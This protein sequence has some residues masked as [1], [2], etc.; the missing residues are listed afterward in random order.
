[1]GFATQS[2][3]TRLGL[4]RNQADISLDGTGFF[5]SPS[6]HCDSCYQ[7]TSKSGQVTYHH[8]MLVEFV[9]NPSHKQVLPL[10]FEPISKEDGQVKNDCERNAAKRWLNKYRT[11]TLI[12]QARSWRRGLRPKCPSYSSA[13]GSSMPLHFGGR[14]KTTINFCTSG[15]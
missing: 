13:S 15:F 3:F 10:P 7:K 8:Q 11:S 12:C 5:S 6:I 14:R 9:V 1:M 4:F 2:I